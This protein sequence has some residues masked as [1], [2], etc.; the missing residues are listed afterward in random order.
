MRLADIRPLLSEPFAIRLTGGERIEL[1][2]AELNDRGSA[3]PY[4]QYSLKF[5]GDARRLLPQAIYEISHEDIGTAQWMLVP[6][7]KNEQGYEY[8]AVFSVKK[9][10]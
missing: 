10:E 9:F 4:E 1:R 3:G 6:I 7:G 8:E 2:L 5:Q